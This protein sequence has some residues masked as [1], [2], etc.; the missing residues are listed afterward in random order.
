LEQPITFETVYN[1]WAKNSNIDIPYQIYFDDIINRI[2]NKQNFTFIRI[3]DGEYY[4]MFHKH[5][6]DD[7]VDSDNINEL[8][9]ELDDLV[10]IKK[11]D[12]P[13]LLIGIQHGTKY[14]KVFEEEINTTLSNLKEEGYPCSLFSWAYAAN[15][16]PTLFSVLNNS[17]RPLI[18]MGPHYLNHF[19]YFHIS[20]FVETPERKSW[21]QQYRLEPQLENEINKY[22]NPIIIYCCSV[23]GK[24]AISRNYKKYKNNITQIDLGSNLDPYAKVFSRAWHYNLH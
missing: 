20:S 6:V 8:K 14:D 12:N 7:Q 23:S 19:P 16:L 2:T 22:E 5:S 17:G 10:L 1:E 24:L 9:N 11:E 4:I 18:L 15:K 13:D 21:E 3:C